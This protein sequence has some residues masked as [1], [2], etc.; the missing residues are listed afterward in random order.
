[1]I[2]R[3]HC[4][5]VGAGLT[6][7]LVLLACGSVTA[8]DIKTNYMPGTD[9]S[10]Y[11]TYKWVTINN[12]E[13]VDPI[14]TQQ[15]RDAVDTQLA[16]KGMT[17]TD[18]DTADMYVGIQTSIQHQQQWNAYGMGGGWRFGGGMASATS[19]TIQIGTLVVDFYDPATKQMIWRGVATK[20]LNPSKNAQT[21]LNR[22]NQGVAKLLKTF[23]PKA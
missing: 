23:P 22:I 8:Q 11:H 6:M 19:S 3:W 16:G 13:Q 17:K 2:S 10:K 12:T 1:M 15:I 5:V 7:G 18:A 14:I 20:T 9:F 21:N 4:V